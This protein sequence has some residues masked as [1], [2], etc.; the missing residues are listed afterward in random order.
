M[1]KLIVLSPAEVRG[2]VEEHVAQI[3]DAAV[4]CLG[5]APPELAQDI[6]FEGI[7]LVGGGSMLR[8]MTQRSPTGPP[9][10]STWSTPR[11]SVSRSVRALLESF[12]RLRPIFAAADR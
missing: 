2:A 4:T 12:D 5:N 11:S 3:V 10:R 7:H 1:P 8:G 9:S 6:I